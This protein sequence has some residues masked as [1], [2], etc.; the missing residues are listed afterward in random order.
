MSSL[1][2]IIIPAYNSERVI[3]RC[4]QSL[5]NQTYNDFEIIIVNDGSKDKTQIICNKFSQS[6]S[7]IRVLT[8]QN[9]GRVIA[10]REGY[11][12]AKGE[13]IMFVD[14]D[15]YL[16]KDALSN[17]YNLIVNLQVDCVVGTRARVFGAIGLFK[18]KDPIPISG[19]VIRGEQLLWECYG[20][21]NN[22]GV[23]DCLPGLMWG[24]IYKKKCIDKAM[25]IDPEHLFSNS[26][27]EDWWFSLILLQFMS[28]LYVTDDIVYYWRTGGSS[29][30]DYPMLEESKGYFD[31]RYDFMQ[32]NGG[33]N[34]LVRTFSCFVST[35]I[36]ETSLRV[37]S[38]KYDE[39]QI[40]DFIS[41]QFLNQKIVKWAQVHKNEIPLELKKI[42]DPVLN[43]C[44]KELYESIRVR[45]SSMSNSLRCILKN[46]Y[47]KLESF[48]IT[49]K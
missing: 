45:E 47:I 43:N 17:L 36:W 14:H 42:S 30:G 28:S 18:K 33:G 32:N 40:L 20:L 27:L 1:I 15:D 26:L 3:T 25:S 21:S 24:R 4:V 35:L 37:R 11:L 44:P 23:D 19:R 7:R 34:L 12:L 46:S 16:P 10:R 41:H 5:L 6:D 38:G 22:F 49:N 39:K 2:S 48:L 31:Y 9:E 8:K 29:S 13:Y